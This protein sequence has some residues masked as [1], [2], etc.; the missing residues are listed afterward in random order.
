VGADRLVTDRD[1]RPMIERD[2]DDAPPPPRQTVRK[3]V[4]QT[5]LIDIGKMDAAYA[6]LTSNSASF[7]RWFAP[8]RPVVFCDDPDAI[9]LVK[10]IGAD[11][12]VIL[13]PEGDQ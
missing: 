13:A 12:T 9:L 3:S 11:P 5:R 8:D 7:A 4:V 6:A 2:Y 10:A 1:G